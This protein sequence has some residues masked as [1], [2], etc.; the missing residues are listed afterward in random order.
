MVLFSFSLKI[1]K[2]LRGISTRD[3]EN[4]HVNSRAHS[5]I[6]QVPRAL[7]KNNHRCS[8]F[9]AHLYFKTSTLWDKRAVMWHVLFVFFLV[10]QTWVERTVN[11]LDPRKYYFRNNC[12]VCFKRNQSA[13]CGITVCLCYI[14]LLRMLNVSSWTFIECFYE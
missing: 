12:K 13:L 11:T 4:F 9:A 5:L 6:L 14:N 10:L 8:K 3:F 2:R 7:T 1:W